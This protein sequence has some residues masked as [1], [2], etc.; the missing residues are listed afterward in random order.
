MVRWTLERDVLCVK[1][2]LRKTRLIMPRVLH[3]ECLCMM[4]VH[5]LHAVRKGLM[6]T[7]HK[8]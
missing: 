8:K 1:V 7:P 3:G 6:C 2:K 4:P 5:L